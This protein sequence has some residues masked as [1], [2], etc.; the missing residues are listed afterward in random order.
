MGYPYRQIERRWRRAWRRFECH[1]AVRRPDGPRYFI[2]DSAPFP[3]GSLHMGH[4]RTYVLGDVQAR[5]RRMAGLQVLYVSGFDAFGLPIELE[6]ISRGLSPQELVAKSR[7]T[8]THQLQQLGISYDWSLV[9]CTSDPDCYRHTQWL[10]LEMYEAGLVE[11]REAEIPWCPQCRTGL[12]RLQIEAGKCW[13]CRTAVDTRTM[14]QW[15]ILSSRYRKDLLK[16]LDTLDGWSRQ[17]KGLLRGLLH[18][19]S[20]WLV[21]RQRSWGTPIPLVHCDRC[22]VV[23]VAR[24]QLPVVLPDDLDWA[25]GS[26]ALARHPEFSRVNCPRC[27]ADARRETDTLDCYFDDIWCFMQCLVVSGDPPGFTRGNLLRWLPA[28][29]CQCGLD[30]ASYFNLY[31]LLGRFLAERGFID[32]PE[33]IRR[34]HGNAMVMAGTRKMSKH[35]GN[36]VSPDTVMQKCGAD[37]LRLAIL[38]AAQP[39]KNVPWSDQLVQKARRLLESSERLFGELLPANARGIHLDARY[40]GSPATGPESPTNTSVALPDSSSPIAHTPRC[41][42]WIAGIESCPGFSW[43]VF[44]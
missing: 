2:H 8:M 36:A 1:R 4:V 23:P 17:V 5:Y 41:P 29:L 44:P 15:F 31:R 27:D 34:Y 35:L 18:D 37:A 26:G 28:D 13:R 21:S 25:G 3:N 7:A 6:A 14:V 33:T 12:A 30:T 24:D 9:Q 32:D 40:E 42:S 10:F 38:W 16:T 39:S 22:G 11:H 19:P 43:S 20:D